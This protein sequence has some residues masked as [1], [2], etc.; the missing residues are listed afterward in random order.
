M[1]AFGLTLAGISFIFLMTTLGSAVAFLLKNDLSKKTQAFVFGL[2][3][4]IMIASSIWS[5]ILPALDSFRLQFKAFAFLPAVCAVALGGV[6][7]VLLDVVLPLINKK[8]ACAGVGLTK[9]FRMFL[10]VTFHNIP[11]GLAVGFAFGVANALNEPTAV[12]GALGLAFGIGIQNFP[13]GMAVVL[14]MKTALK[15]NKKAFLWGVGSGGVE[16][17]FAV[18]GCILA[19]KLKFLQPWLLSASAG[20]MLFVSAGDLIPDSK[21]PDNPNIGAWGVLIGFLFMMALDVGLG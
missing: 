19:F 9:S 15:S 7:L 11:E 1:T 10:A 4:G 16:P 13:E 2:A 12:L 21:T 3:S 6:F 8:T 18:L 20:A 14:P 17:I 5:L